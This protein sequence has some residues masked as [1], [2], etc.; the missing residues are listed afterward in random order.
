[1]NNYFEKVQEIAENLG[2]NVEIQD[3][4]AIFQR[5][6]GCGQDFNIELDIAETSD[7]FADNLYNYYSE[8]D[9]SYETYLWLDSTGHGTNGAPYEMI[10][11]YN[12]MKEC[13]EAIHEL[14]AEIHN[15]DFDE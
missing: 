11:V 14:W 5:Y 6:S 12:D 10:D 1:M 2:W 13:E 15:T 3:N 7:E 8:F 9:V 4:I